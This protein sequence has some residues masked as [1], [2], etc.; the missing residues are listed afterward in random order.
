M[1]KLS[2][3]LLLAC[4]TLVVNTNAQSWKSLF[5]GKNLKGWE[6]YVGP[7]EKDGEPIG[8]NKDP[9]NLFSV[10]ELDGEKVIRI[11]GEINASLS[12]KKEFE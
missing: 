12:T 11:S 3:I 2:F 10:V 7:K 8:L 5:N 6:T 9:M 1:K 4:V